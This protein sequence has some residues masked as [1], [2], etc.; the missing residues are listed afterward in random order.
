MICIGLKVDF[1]QIKVKQVA[2]GIDHTL[3]VSEDGK[4]YAFGSNKHFKLGHS[5]D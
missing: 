1:Q 5:Q 2:C 4:V 3:L